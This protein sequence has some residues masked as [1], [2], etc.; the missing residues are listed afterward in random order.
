MF[1]HYTHLDFPPPVSS[2]HFIDYPRLPLLISEQF[3]GLER[4]VFGEFGITP[5]A[6]DCLQQITVTES[7][8]IVWS[9]GKRYMLC[10]LCPR[11][12][13]DFVKVVVQTLRIGI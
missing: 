11:A 10:M 12:M 5:E 1:D 13:G 4:K 7:K 2:P 6:P 9:V 8:G 3:L